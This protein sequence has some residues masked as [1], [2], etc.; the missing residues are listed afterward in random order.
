MKIR[1]L[2]RAGL[3]GRKKDSLL[4]VLVIVLA[5]VFIVTSTSFQA[6]TEKTKKEQSL[7][8]YGEWEAAFLEADGDILEDLKAEKDIDKIGFSQIIGQSEKAG[9][10][11]SFNQDLIN[12]GRL[13]LYKGE[14]PKED[15]EIMVELNQM[16]LMGLD[17][18]VGQKLALEISIPRNLDPVENFIVRSE[19]LA[20]YMEEEG[21][22]PSLQG[23]KIYEV[24]SNLFYEQHLLIHG[25]LSGDLSLE[26][27]YKRHQESFKDKY[28]EAI[29]ALS[30]LPGEDSKKIKKLLDDYGDLL[31]KDKADLGALQAKYRE[32]E[33]KIYSNE[34]MK[35][36][37]VNPHNEYPNEKIGDT[38]I[39]VSSSFFHYYLESQEAS[40]KVARQKGVLVEQKITLKKEFIITGILE[41]YSDK[42]DKGDFKLANAFI[43]EG[44][45]VLLKDAFYNNS[46]EDFSDYEMPYHIFLASDRLGANLYDRLKAS[47]PDKEFLGWD[48][49]SKEYIS[50]L[51]G[52]M[53]E[54]RE[55]IE[56]SL[57]EREGPGAWE[58]SYYWDGRRSD[59]EGRDS[60]IE[61]I[62]DSGEE[63]LVNN[64][65]FRRNSF[66]YG[67]DEG[68]AE[69]ILS[70]T[71]IGIIFIATVLAILQ[72]FLTQ[73]KRRSRKIV[74]LKSIGASKGQI[75]K[76]VLYEGL[77]FLRKGAL[78]GIPLGLVS[79]LG[80]VYGM[81][82]FGGR[83]LS[84][85]IDPYFLVWGIL[86][87]V[88]ALFLGILVPMIF[89]IRIPLVGS[90]SKAP[91][92]SKWRR[93]G[94]GKGLAYQSF[95][96]INIEY[97][98]LNR[99][100]TLISFG[101]SFIIITIL[102]TSSFL[103][104]RSFNGYKEE[105]LEKSRPDYAL[106]AIYGESNPEIRRQREGLL[107]I[108]GIKSVETYKV[109][110]QTFLWYK[111]IGKNKLLNDFEELLPLELRK[112]YFSKYNGELQ[113]ENQEPGMPKLQP[114]IKNAFLTKIY[115][116]D[117]E[118]ELFNKYESAL[119]L[120]KIDPEKFK[121]GD[122]VILMVPNYIEGD[123]GLGDRKFT[124]KEVL[125]GSNEDNRMS[126]IFEKSGSYKQ[127]YDE[128]YKD[129]Y[130][131]DQ[132][133]KVGD[134][135]YISADM[136]DLNDGG[137][138][139]GYNSRE[140]EV[141]GIINYLAQGGSWP[142]SNSR[143][144]YVIISS[145]D[146]M[147]SIYPLASNGLRNMELKDMERGIKMLY[148]TR[149]GRTLWYINT[150]S[151]GK[152]SVLDS[153]LLAFAHNHNYTIYNY[154]ESNSKLFQ[155][156]LN[157]ALI[158][159]LLGLTAA[160]IALVILYNILLSKAEQDKNRIGILQALGVTREEFTRYNLLEGLI[161][162]GLSLVLAHLLLLLI[163]FL[164]AKPGVSM[165]LIGRLR[166]IFVYDLWLYPWNWH[167]ILSISYLILMVVIYYLPTRKIIRNSPVENI[168]A[169]GR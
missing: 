55:S 18:E 157:N 158:I 165:G 35:E 12:L 65:N 48:Q 59:D 87:G 24:L 105:V 100:K 125:D 154:R 142:F 112:N 147:T 93:T 36:I 156:G 92:H 169:L 10:V 79:S 97:L 161:Q 4:I 119:S 13:K 151:R 42:W 67:G 76:M 31:K 82:K 38:S 69:S 51:Y 141:G 1:D 145:N 64:S 139:L 121:K 163:L 68:S 123:K 83:N 8:L 164:T 111:G 7:D 61:G 149:Y 54:S 19:E 78:L 71:I 113:D 43:T 57:E 94:E 146:A 130:E 74:L 28:P 160:G 2:A 148:P 110:K 45:A 168:R 3:K 89:A 44:G 25:E 114:Y 63:M 129:Y 120:G 143:A 81:N 126:W 14:I 134:K 115:A 37:Q 66:A 9:L 99:T 118:G 73:M 46:I 60:S 22:I 39:F 84:F 106:E 34:K 98:K 58:D 167:I 150:D 140:V 15:N 91:K 131:R 20:R 30:I 47:Y 49:P 153:E 116:I 144:S 62:W 138:I 104:Y 124:K 32:I 29:E 86:A 162:G 137:R 155:T 108:E 85:F 127:S 136:E 132:H 33:E 133:I 23:N 50:G 26:E 122:Q 95:L 103:S 72:I 5:F 21:I 17:L 159:G 56:K 52:L 6:S 109:G 27:R 90:M 40:P 117:P 152:D 101:I 107:E 80:L 70:F 135:V 53:G 41:S 128:R 75:V 11:G 96:R 16:S 88:L 166:D 77:Y 102:I